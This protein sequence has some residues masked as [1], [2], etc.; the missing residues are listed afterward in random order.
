MLERVHGVPWWGAVLIAVVLTA[1][2]FGIDLSSTAA[3]G[4]FAWVLTL[5]GVALSTLGV[6]RHAIFTPMVQPPLVVAFSLVVAYLVTVSTRV[7]GIGLTVINAFPLMVTAT[8]VA[9]V[10]GMIRIVTQPLRPA[11]R[12]TTQP[13]RA[14]PA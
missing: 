3:V 5:L 12:A 1:L 6:R 11:R 9:L 14:N 8:A 10:L 7:L 4:V 2:G 13:R